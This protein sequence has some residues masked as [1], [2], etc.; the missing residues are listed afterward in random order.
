M[1]SELALVIHSKDSEI[2]ALRLGQVSHEAVVAAFKTEVQGL[3]VGAFRMIESRFHGSHVGE[4]PNLSSQR[5][6]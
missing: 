4:G 6:W 5:R 3:K 2:H 1:N